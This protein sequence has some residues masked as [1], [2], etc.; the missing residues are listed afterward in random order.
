MIYQMVYLQVL[1]Y[2]LTKQLLSGV[3][4]K[5]LRM[6]DLNDDLQKIRKWAY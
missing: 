4:D 3:R 2:L 6:K 1:N 5:N